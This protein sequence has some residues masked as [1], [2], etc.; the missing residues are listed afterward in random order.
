M[1]RLYTYW[2]SSTAYRVR[3]GLNL[4]GLAFEPVAVDLSTVEN[5]APAFLAVNPQGLVP[6]LEIDGRLLVQSLPILEYLD[7]RWPEPPLLP[8]DPEARARVRALADT[9][10]CDIHPL[11]NAR[12]LR[13]LKDELALTQSQR[14]AWYGH[15][16]AE[17]LRAFDAWLGPDDGAAFCCGG[18]PTL[19]DVCLVPQLY[20]AR[21]FGCALDEH[22]R[23]VRIE[24]ACLARA[25]FAQAAPETQPD[26]F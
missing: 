17:G 3:I 13:Y 24:Q 14:D 25:A 2:R 9:V 7:E 21:R 18:A 22:P 5:R 4:K 12:V 23:L 20:N 26:R 1:I 8:S 11:N 15:W 19:A 16:I 10:A 6:A